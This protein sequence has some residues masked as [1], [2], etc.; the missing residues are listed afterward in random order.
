MEIAG[1]YPEP[2]GAGAEAEA[3]VVVRA[4]TVTIEGLQR[5]LDAFMLAVFEGVRGYNNPP[6]AAAINSSPVQIATTHARLIASVGNLTGIDSTQAVQNER[7]QHLAELCLTKKNRILELE[8]MIL[9]S[10]LIIDRK[11]EQVCEIV[12]A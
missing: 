3:G 2:V 7:I 1:E 8:N 10:K 5:M 4:E 6:A 9:E 11:L 12:D